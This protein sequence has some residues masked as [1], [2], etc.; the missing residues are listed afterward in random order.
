[1]IEVVE[2]ENSQ[3]TVL[4][5]KLRPPRLR[6]VLERP[7]LLHQTE[8]SRAP[9]LINICAGPGFGKTTLM[10]QMAREFAG[11]SVWYQA[12]GLDRD[13]AVFLRHLISGISHACG[14]EGT[15][16]RSRLSDVTDF[17]TESES[18]LAVMIDELGEHSQVPVMICF[19]DYHLFDNGAHAPRCIE[20]L[21]QNLPEKSCVVIAARS[22]PEITL[23]RLRTQGL[24]RD[25]KDEDLQF[26]LEE[27]SSLTHAWEIEVSPTVLKKVQKST[28]GWAA[29]LVLTENYLRSGSDI[30]DL[31]SHHRMQQHVYEYLA[32][33]VLRNLPAEIQAIL[34]QISL[35]D[36]IDPDICDKALENRNVYEVLSEAEQ[37]NLFTNRLDQAELYRY[38]PLFRDFLLSRLAIQAGKEG[39][40]E[41]RVKFAEAFVAAGYKRPAIEQYL[42]AGQHPEAVA[43]IEKIGDEMLDTAE[44][45]TLE[46]WI[47]S[48]DEKD[49]TPAIQIQRAMILM[50]AGKFRKALFLL[51]T[52]EINILNDD[53]EQFCSF[54]LVKAECLSNLDQYEDAISILKS[55]LELSLPTTIRQRALF[56]LCIV[57]W[58]SFDQKGLQT[59]LNL[60]LEDAS[61]A[62]SQYHIEIRIISCMRN[63]RDG[64]FIKAHELLIG[65]IESGCLSES[66]KNMHLNNLASC[67]MMMGDYSS[68]ISIAEECKKRIEKQRE[69]KLFAVACDTLGC[70][71]IALDSESDGHRLLNEALERTS[72]IDLQSDDTNAALLCHL[73]SYA[74]RQGD[75]KTAFDYHV[76]SVVYAEKFCGFYE[77][78][79]GN[80]NIGADL[81]H[82]GR[83]IEAEKYFKDAYKLAKQH[84]FRYV[85]TQID[86]NRAWAAYAKNDQEQMHECISL[87]LRRAKKFQHN[88]YIIQEGK[89]SLPLL[90]T[91]LEIGVEEDYVCWLLERI[92]EKSLNAIEPLLNHDDAVTRERIAKL[93][94][95]INSSGALTLLRRMR[96]DS[97]ERVKKTV[98]EALSILRKN[99][100]SPT[101]L[102]TARETEVLE[103]VSFGLTNNQIAK[104]LFISERTVKTHVAKIF[105]KLGFTNR[106][107]AALYFKKSKERNTTIHD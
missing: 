99:I 26:S 41:L 32:E 10:A 85:R 101:E 1:M 67:L 80:A 83:F 5:S 82:M 70:L 31:F 44:Y 49:I 9:R 20:Y 38:H 97:N 40:N 92:G 28:E 62:F 17:T 53:I 36:P 100:I 98:K 37:S 79:T 90:T 69:W 19:D 30:P 86:F 72:N 47:D 12:D 27:L 84:D 51:T 24:L 6:K 58:V 75:A 14:F 95:D 64:N 18:V 46:N 43:I 21:L 2:P 11:N 48:L 94:C 22:Y 33:E 102:L 74:R 42:A 57:Y 13:P 50:S 16:A 106:I 8:S 77:Q 23:G 25:L 61:S 66:H 34:I 71:M 54:M 29:G 52:L 96:Y 3:K 63:L 89:I 60:A 76:K 87:A 55:L 93:L 15:R 81:V 107:D 103:C 4:E 65:N 59:S 73:G 45:G 68:A 35:I 78:A 91:A 39:M 104:K 56:Q 7:R 105:R 88:H